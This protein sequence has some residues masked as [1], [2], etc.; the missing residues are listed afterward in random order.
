MSMQRR[1]PASQHA[2]HF[3]N[4]QTDRQSEYSAFQTIQAP[5]DT[6][7]HYHKSET[8]RLGTQLELHEDDI[9]PEKYR[10]D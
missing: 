5:S 6:L 7:L 1:Q 4:Q 3:R 10:D 2:T 9:W 8:Y